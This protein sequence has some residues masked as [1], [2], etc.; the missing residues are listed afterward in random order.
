MVFIG[1]QHTVL[2]DCVGNPAIRLPRIGVELEEVTDLFLTHF[3][4]DHV[5]AVPI[6][7][8]DMWL[9]GRQKTLHIHGLEYTFSR[10]RKMMELYSWN[11]WAGFFPIVFHTIPES[12]LHRAIENEDFLIQTAPVTHLIPTIGMRVDFKRYD[13]SVA[14]SCDTEPDENVVCLAEGADVLIHEAAGAVKG[15]SSAAQAAEIAQQ[16]EVGQLLLIH[17]PEKSLQDKSL[18][19]E[20]QKWY[21]GNIAYAV[22]LQEIIPGE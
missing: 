12:G 11:E 21:S 16:A 7:L 13:F 5:A 18:L 22:D 2:V 15:H 6:L 3:H 8:M 9:L 19:A 10:V 4:P 14:Y 1:D 20:A 17:Y